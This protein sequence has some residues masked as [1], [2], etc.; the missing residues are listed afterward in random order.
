MKKGPFIVFRVLGLLLVLGLIAGAGAFGFKAGMMRGIEQAPEVAAAIE[1]AAEDGQPAAPMY[2][3]GYAYGYP[4]PYGFGFHHHFNPF[5]AICGSIFFLFLFFGFMK[6]MFFRRMRHGWG[7]H[8]HHGPWGKGWEGNVP[9][10]F[11]EWHKRAHGEKPA[12]SNSEESD[13]PEEK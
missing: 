9:P 13:K 11:E 12:E 6:M 2:G 10:P 1:K 5:G 4:Q 7:H 3:H 8:G